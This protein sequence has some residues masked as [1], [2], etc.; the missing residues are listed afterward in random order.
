MASG[1]EGLP[2]SESIQNDPDHEVLTYKL[3]MQLH[4]L[5]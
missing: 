5:V 2:S 1:L 3:K 4:R